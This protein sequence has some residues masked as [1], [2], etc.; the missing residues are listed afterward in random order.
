MGQT[1][2]RLRLAIK[3]FKEILSSYSEIAARIRL[4]AEPPC[5]NPTQPYWSIPPS[6]IANHKSTLPDG[7]V[8]IVIIGS[9]ITG[10]SVAR[11]ILH[12]HGVSVTVVMI[13]AR[14]LCSG[15]TGRYAVIRL[16]TDIDCNFLIEMEV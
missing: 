3:E 15:A 5:K 16:L 14:E 8:D 1:I 13:E 9:G 12:T 2:S 11:G 7:D 4:P 6:P 10:A